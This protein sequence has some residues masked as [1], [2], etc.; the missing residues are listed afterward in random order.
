MA[1]APGGGEGHTKEGHPGKSKRL[2]STIPMDL[3]MIPLVTLR[4]ILATHLLC[5]FLAL[6]E[7]GEM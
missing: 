7:A 1:A 6:Y 5:L 2:H 3:S 4:I